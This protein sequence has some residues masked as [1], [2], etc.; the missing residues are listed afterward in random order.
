MKKTA[1][2]ITCIIFSYVTIVGAAFSQTKPMPGRKLQ[3]IVVNKS[4]CEKVVSI[5]SVKSVAKESLTQQVRIV[6]KNKGQKAEALIEVK[7][8]KQGK[9]ANASVLRTTKAM[10]QM[11]IHVALDECPDES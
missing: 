6:C 9:I 3:Q 8:N 7:F 10:G 1:F 11:S 4:S 5:T 2:V